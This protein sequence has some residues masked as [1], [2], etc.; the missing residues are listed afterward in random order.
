MNYGGCVGAISVH[1]GTTF[2]MTA[3]WDEMTC[4]S[5][6]VQDLP[7][8]AELRL[9]SELAVEI[10]GD[11][12][13]ILWNSGNTELCNILARCLLSLAG[14]E[15]FVRR[16]PFWYRPGKYVPVFHVPPAFNDPLHV[17]TKSM[18]R[19]FVP[20]APHFEMPQP[21]AREAAAVQIV[22]DDHCRPRL[23]TALIAPLTAVIA[24]ADGQPSG[25]LAQFEA[26][27]TGCTDITGHD[28]AEVLLIGHEGTLPLLSV[29]S[30]FWGSGVLV[31]VGFRLDPHL[32]VAAM[33]RLAGATSDELVL[34]SHEGYE[35]IDRAQSCR[36][37][38]ARL[39]M[40]GIEAAR[41]RTW[42]ILEAT[43]GTGSGTR[44]RS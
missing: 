8:L 42:P 9:E 7:R 10:A 23:A 44:D 18:A 14:V 16:D 38:R 11:R 39:A 5:I 22:R 33:R 35:L 6:P 21:R 36:L 28:R 40:A 17:S 12:I 27:W 20:A 43:P 34:W 37:D 15:T 3:Q 31:P 41:A 24:W 2:T 32:P 19:T 25:Q 30:R 1:A 4:A 13:W 29:G 26:L